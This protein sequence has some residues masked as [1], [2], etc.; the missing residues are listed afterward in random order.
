MCINSIN[1]SFAPTSK[2]KTSI[3]AKKI[4]GKVPGCDMPENG[5]ITG[6]MGK[7]AKIP[8]FTTPINPNADR[9]VEPKYPY[10]M[11]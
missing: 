4:F 9:T 8:P 2:S 11:A 7:P 10:W 1:S 6:R 3:L 5:G